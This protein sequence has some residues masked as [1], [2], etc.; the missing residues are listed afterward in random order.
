[1]QMSGLF[2]NDDEITNQVFLNK[3]RLQMKHSIKLMNCWNKKWKNIN[4]W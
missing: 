2:E 3:L 1:M 4:S